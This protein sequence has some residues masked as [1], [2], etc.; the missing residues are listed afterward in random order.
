MAC[1]P[2][3]PAAQVL[4]PISVETTVY[5]G[6]GN[7]RR[8]IITVAMYRVT[9]E[10]GAKDGRA[11]ARLNPRSGPGA[12]F[13]ISAGGQGPPVALASRERGPFAAA[14]SQNAGRVVRAFAAT[15][16]NQS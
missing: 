2:F 8:I 4:T 7:L 5:V 10:S 15:S 13:H 12:P 11:E 14:D 9:I 1:P 16:G 6:P 3:D